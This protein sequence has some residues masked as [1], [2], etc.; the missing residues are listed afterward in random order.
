[1]VLRILGVCHRVSIGY[2]AALGAS[3]ASLVAISW[4]IMDHD[5]RRRY[6]Y[7][8]ESGIIFATRL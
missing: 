5:R 4:N 8:V 1:M 2:Y 3:V 7:G 6:R